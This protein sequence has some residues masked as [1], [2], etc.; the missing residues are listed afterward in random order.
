MRLNFLYHFL[1][2]NHKFI[3]NN[4]LNKIKILHVLMKK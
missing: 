1:E 4:F 2:Q 3:V